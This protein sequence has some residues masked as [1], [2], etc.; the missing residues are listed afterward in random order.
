[1]SKSK[2]NVIDPLDIVDGIDLEALV[3]KRTSGLMQPQLRAGDREGDAQAVSRR[4]SPPHGTDALRFTFAALASPSRDISFDL[5]RVD[6][7][8]NFCNKLWNAARFVTLTRRRD[9]PSTS[10]DRG[11]GAVGGRPLDPL[12]LRPRRSPRVESAFADYRFDFA[13]SALYEFAWYEFCDWYLELTKP[14]L[15]GESA[16]PA[17]RSAARAARWLECSKR[18]CARCTRS[19]RSSPKR[20]GSASRRSPAASG[21]H[22]MLQP[23]PTAADFPRRR[24]GRARSRLDA[25]GG[26]GRTADPR[27]DGHQRRRRRSRVLLQDAGAEDEALAARHRALLE[28][29][30]GHGEPDACSAPGAAAP[31]SAAALVG[32]ADAAR[33]HGGP[34][35][36]RRPRPSGSASSSPRPQAD[37]AKTRGQARQRQLRAQRPGGGGRHRARARRRARAHRHRTQR[38]ARAGARAA[39]AMSS[40]GRRAGGRG[41]A[42]ARARLARDGHPRQ[43][44]A[45]PAVPRLP[46]GARPP[47]D[48]GRARASARPRSRTRWRT[49]WDSPGSACSSPATCCPRTS[50]ACRCSTAPA[51]SFNFRQGPI[52][53]QLLLA[54]EI[55][56]ASP[57]TQSA[58]LEAMEERQVSVDG[59]TYR[60]ARAVLR[61][62]H[63]E[64]ARAARHLRAARVAARPLPHARHARLPRRRARARAAARRA[65]GASCCRGIAAGAVGRGRACACSA[66]CARVHVADALLDYAQALIARTRER[67]D[68]KL[69]LSPRAG[70]G[71]VRA[72]QAWA[73][74]AG[75]P[76]RAAR[77]RAGGARRPWSRTGSSARDPAPGA[78]ADFAAE[79]VRAVPVPL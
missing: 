40:R 33:A 27:R 42:G 17:A 12:A 22:V 59:T 16:T 75:A 64:P 43:A 67:T 52:F 57:R 72:A 58:L 49:C 46:A 48:R 50:S 23:Y 44:G 20:S 51:S 74:L 37:L 2:G 21:R 10:G 41:G 4:A 66:R 18:C 79:I 26:P 60:A 13:A 69:G 35:R 47:A 15:Q 71:L 19:C 78:P 62:R 54:D 1:M 65:S 31:Q 56:R 70:Q 68:L 5:A 55:N 6:G 39:R 3:A 77:G 24:G 38:A 7:Y 63:A 36:C 30:A 32:D 14:V 45:D 76:G 25:G 8:R 28:R 29:L 11:D 34:H 73:Y 53:T 9:A 61:G